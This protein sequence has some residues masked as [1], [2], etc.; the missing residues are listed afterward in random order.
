MQYPFPGMDPYLEHRNLWPGA[1]NR[2]IVSLANQIQ[3]RLLPRYIASI[4]QRVFVEGPDREIIPDIRVRRPRPDPAPPPAGAA[5]PA[6]SPVILTVDEVE[7]KESYIQV[8]DRYAQM[9]VVAVIEV[10]SPSNKRSRKGRRSYRQKQRE[11]LAGDRHLVEIDL[12]RSGPHVLSVPSWRA[13][14]LGGYDYLAC[15][16]R[17]PDRTKY[18]LY[19]RRLRDRLPRVRV[20]LVEPDADVVMDVQAAVE[21]IYQEG[22]YA[23]MLRYQEPCEPP[24]SAEDQQWANERIAAFQAARPDLFSR[25]TT[26]GAANSP[27]AGR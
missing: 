18:E 13:T 14:D 21:Q 19:P 12:L 23:L 22:G 10:V 5:S 20:P 24:L 11:T 8:L 16:S 7:V 6:D 3:P 27:Q 1:H 17:S 2:L 9:R 15:V 4:E 25:P 26:N